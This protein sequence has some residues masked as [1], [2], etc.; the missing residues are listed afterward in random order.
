MKLAYYPGCSLGTSAVEYGIS[1]RRTAE[2]MGIDL[3]EIQDWNCCGATSA[4]NTSKLLSLA[5]PAR[6]LA[7]AEQAGLDVLA[8][9]AAC[10]N[11][12]RATEH[13]IRKDSTTREK[14]QQAIEMDYQATNS[15]LSVLELLA[16]KVGIEAIK[17]KVTNPL[18]GMKAACY[19]G[20]LLVRPVELTGFD[21]PE[22]P[23]TMDN[24]VRALG[25]S[26]VEWAFKTECC[27]ASL[28]TSRPDVGKKMIYEVLNNARQNGAECIVTAC[29]LCMMNLDMRQASVEKEFAVSFNIPIYYVTELLAIACGDSP[30]RVNTHRHFVEAAKYLDYIKNLPDQPVTEEKPVKAGAPQETKA[31]SETSE[32]L[33]P[34]SA[35]DE[36]EAL[37]KKI[38]GMIKGLEKNPDKMAAKLITDVER[39]KVLSQIILSDPKKTAKLAELMVTDKDKAAKVAE[40]FVTGELKKRG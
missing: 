33:Q 34:D 1:M 23:Q 24:I 21:D 19:Y 10:Y 13:V 29:P 2:L 7:R 5:L 11:R 16:H 32:K 18:Q 22:D 30:R 6:N 15:T 25:A 35:A 36:A 28:A 26:T 12:F 8:P 3:E 27:G 39:A 40:A 37:Q 17:S 4:H 31:E 20:C 38:T 9:C 14:V